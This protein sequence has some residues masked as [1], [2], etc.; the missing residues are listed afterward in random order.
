M[1]VL[2]L[3]GKRLLRLNTL[4]RKRTWKESWQVPMFGPRKKKFHAFERQHCVISK[5]IPFSEELGCVA[6]SEQL[7]SSKLWESSV[8][9]LCLGVKSTR[10]LF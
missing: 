8:S 1:R 10:R 2:N 4:H 7:F 9:H 5:F 3:A 6:D